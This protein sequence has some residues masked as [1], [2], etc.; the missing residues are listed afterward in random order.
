MKRV[1]LIAGVFLLYGG[2]FSAATAQSTRNINPSWSPDG[3]QLAFVSNRE[4]NPE[5]YIVDAS[6]GVPE[7]LSQHGG[8]DL[9]PASHP[10][11]SRFPSAPGLESLALLAVGGQR[12]RR[13]HRHLCVR[14][15][16]LR[17]TDGRP[18]VSGE[19]PS[20]PDRRDS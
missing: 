7:N 20:Q 4:G 18:R 17:D 15:A 9:S 6:G 14:G 2:H 19:W 8:L 12:G 10:Y 1:A 5:I 16:G 11:L 3:T 13:T